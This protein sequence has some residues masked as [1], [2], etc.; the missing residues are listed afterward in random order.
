MKLYFFCTPLPGRKTCRNRTAQAACYLA[1]WT[2]ISSEARCNRWLGGCS[3][4]FQDHL[5]MCGSILIYRLV[6]FYNLLT[7]ADIHYQLL[8]LRIPSKHYCLLYVHITN[9]FF[10]WNKSKKSL[11]VIVFCMS[12]KLYRLSSFNYAKC[13]RLFDTVKN[14][15]DSH[16]I[17]YSARIETPHSDHFGYGLD[18]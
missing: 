2:R 6:F 18:E 15:I 14:I 4:I 16:Q 5:M 1:C 9:I 13:C 8:Q 7:P 3:M 11:A 12:S 17:S 10:W